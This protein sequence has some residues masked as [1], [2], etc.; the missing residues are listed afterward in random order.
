MPLGTTSTM[1]SNDPSASDMDWNAMFSTAAAATED[2]VL[3][4]FYF[5]DAMEVL[6]DKLSAHR[7]RINELLRPHLEKYLF[8]RDGF[9]L[10]ESVDKENIPCL[11]AHLR[12][13]DVQDAWYVF[14]L[15]KAA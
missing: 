1:R 14:W 4:E 7:A 6:D 9:F 13:S 2:F 10:E 11:K 3:A 8:H 5:D 15:V 12:T